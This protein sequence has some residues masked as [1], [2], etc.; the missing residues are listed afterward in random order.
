MSN[1]QPLQV[2]GKAP[3][4]I[5]LYA[6]A[7]SLLCIL[8]CLALPLLAAVLPLAGM[9]S[10]NELVHRGLVWASAPAT[11]WVA[12]LIKGTRGAASFCLVAVCG[13]ALLFLG[14]FASSLEGLEEPLTV[15]GALLV[16]WAHLRRLI[17][18]R[19]KTAFH[20]KLRVAL[21]D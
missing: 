13:Q 2:P 9:L 16:S 6:V 4:G 15:A 1:D 12:W 17:R 8:H 7:L 10:E 14:A 18:Q 3:V 21:S 20:E 19:L 5:D 11:L